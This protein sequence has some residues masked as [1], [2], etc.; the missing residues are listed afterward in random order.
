MNDSPITI[1]SPRPGEI[2][3]GSDERF[4]NPPRGC[5]VL[6]SACGDQARFAGLLDPRG[7]PTQPND[8]AITIQRLDEAADDREM[9]G[10]ADLI[11]RLVAAGA[12]HTAGRITIAWDP[13]DVRGLKVLQQRGFRPT[14]EMPYFEMAGGHVEYVGGYMDAT[15]S[16]MDLSREL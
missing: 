2:D 16:T 7:R 14:G 3:R 1:R 8:P 9:D 15:G 6:V 5:T 10:L 11:E 13:M 4:R 12:D